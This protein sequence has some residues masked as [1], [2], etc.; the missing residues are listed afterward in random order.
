TRAAHADATQIPGLDEIL[1]G[2]LPR[3]ALVIVT[4]PPGSGK[5]ILASQ[6][7]FASA[8]AGR[9]AVVTT[10]LSESPSK[11]I[12]HVGDLDFYDESLVGIGVQFVSLQRALDSGLS[13]VVDELIAVARQTDA[14]LVVVDGF[15]GIRGVDRDPQEARLFLYRMAGTLGTLGVT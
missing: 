4:G 10:T 9:H 5:T 13:G 12:E 1:G 14:R 15:S 7:A 2:G 6:L 11:L 8:H 3:G